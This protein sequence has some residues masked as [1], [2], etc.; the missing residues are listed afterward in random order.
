MNL[1][2]YAG[3]IVQVRTMSYGLCCFCTCAG[4]I[5]LLIKLFIEWQSVVYKT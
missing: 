3:S 5:P 1:Y 2:G 4:G